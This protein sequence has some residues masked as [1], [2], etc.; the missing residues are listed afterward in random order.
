LGA[1]N[2]RLG[3]RHQLLTLIQGQAEC[4]GN[5]EIGAFD[6]RYLRLRNDTRFKLGDELHPP[7][8]RR[9]GL[10]PSP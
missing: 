3:G 9:H 10:I 1:D 5:R 4:L 6:A 8:Q 7:H 2:L